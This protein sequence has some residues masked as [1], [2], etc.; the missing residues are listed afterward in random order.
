MKTVTYKYEFDRSPK[1]YIC[2]NCNKKTFTRYIDKETNKLAPEQFGACDRKE[3]CGFLA[4]PESDK[5]FVLADVPP[6]KPQVFLPPELNSKYVNNG[7][8]SNFFN[9]L[10][11]ITSDDRAKLAFRLYRLGTVKDGSSMHGAVTMP[12]FDHN[13]NLQAIQ[14]KKF[15]DKNHTAATGWAHSHISQKLRK[16]KRELPEWLIDYNENN[17]KCNC[18]FGGHLVLKYP[19]AKIVLVE[20]PKSAIYCTAVKGDPAETGILFLAVFNL[21]GLTFERCECLRCR[22]ILLFPD[23]SPKGTA[24]QIWSQKAEQ[25]SKALECKMYVS[26]F[27]EKNTTADE[28]NS[29][30][31]VADYIQD[32]REF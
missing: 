9:L 11:G 29:G 22:N 12:F 3:K 5:T 7:H 13:G 32:K 24:Y 2:P 8:G 18:L 27:F 23:A 15:D 10:S 19:N 6:P 20:A 26:D 25:L 4:Y 14:F 1:K 30:Y 31:D 16:Q 21:T 17:V 28:K